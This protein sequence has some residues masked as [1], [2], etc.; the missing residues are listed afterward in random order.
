LIAG[1]NVAKTIFYFSVIDGKVGELLSL[2]KALRTKRCIVDRNLD[3]AVL[4][5]RT[6]GILAIPPNSEFLESLDLVLEIAAPA[7]IPIESFKS[8]L[9]MH[10]MPILDC[11]DV[12]KSYLV[13]AHSRVFQESGRKP[14]RYH[15][16]M[17][18]RAD[19]NHADYL[20]YYSN[21]HYRFGIATPLA[22]YY[23]NYIDLEGSAETAGYFGLQPIVA[24]N[25]SEFFNGCD[26]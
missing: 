7:G 2:C 15:Y 21:Q 14:H 10:L 8:E 13:S 12:E 25:I 26:F 11:V 23:Q 24:D 19:F 9:K 20:D 16:L 17:Y 4:R 5:P 6:S 18:R 1:K 3:L 22:D